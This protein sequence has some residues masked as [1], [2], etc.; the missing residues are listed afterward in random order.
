MVFTLNIESEIAKLNVTKYKII[1]SG[2]YFRDF[3]FASVEDQT[4]PRRGLPLR[5]EFAPKGANSFLKS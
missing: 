2:H 5:K 1:K 3:L 4:L